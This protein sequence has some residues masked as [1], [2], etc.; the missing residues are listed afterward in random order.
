MLGAIP[1]IQRLAFAAL[2]WLRFAKHVCRASAI[3]IGGPCPYKTFP[4]FP[5]YCLS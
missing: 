4:G 3:N 5:V 1:A 2:E